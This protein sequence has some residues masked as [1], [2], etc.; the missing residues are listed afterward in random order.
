MNA[1]VVAVML[2]LGRCSGRLRACLAGGSFGLV[3]LFAQAVQI[4]RPERTLVRLAER[5]SDFA[6]MHSY[7]AAFCGYRRCSCILLY[8]VNGYV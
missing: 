5:V 4:D 3:I 2:G 1:L 6:G 8:Q 7:P